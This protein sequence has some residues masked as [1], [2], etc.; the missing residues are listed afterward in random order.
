MQLDI[1]YIM[2]NFPTPST[3]DLD[4]FGK[5]N[6]PRFIWVKIKWE[7]TDLSNFMPYGSV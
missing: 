3:Y 2:Y 1:C 6:T 4:E 5:E 7:E